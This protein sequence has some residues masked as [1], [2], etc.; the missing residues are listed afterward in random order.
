[1]GSTHITQWTQRKLGPKIVAKKVTSMRISYLQKML[2]LLGTIQSSASNWTHRTLLVS[3]GFGIFHINFC[4][5][6]WKEGQTHNDTTTTFIKIEKWNIL[7]LFYLNCVWSYVVLGYKY[8]FV[9]FNP[10]N[11]QL[12]PIFHLLA[13]LVIQNIFQASGL[14]V[15]CLFSSFFH[16]FIG[17]LQ[18]SVK[19]QMLK[20]LQ[21]ILC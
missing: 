7:L 21:L 17:E 11:A 6:Y 5:L 15:K 8:L 1:M 3:V 14:S 4:M 10:L 9:T 16:V 19:C 13:I 2:P 12:N 20:N 18:W